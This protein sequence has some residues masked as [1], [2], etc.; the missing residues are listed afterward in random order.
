[1]RSVSKLRCK[2][3]ID[4]KKHREPEY[5]VVESLWLDAVMVLVGSYRSFSRSYAGRASCMKHFHVAAVAS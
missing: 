3:R 5:G 2:V 4:K 1:V